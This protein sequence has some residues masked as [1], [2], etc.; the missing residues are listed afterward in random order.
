[1][2][3]KIAL[4]TK[5]DISF[6]AIMNSMVKQASKTITVRVPKSKYSFVLELLDNLEFVEIQEPSKEQLVQ[7]IKQGF[8]EVKLIKKGKLP[9]KAAR[10]L[11]HEL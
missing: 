1:L 10:D 7:E 8:K 3:Q 6:S 2:N 9:K 5:L 4:A 11:L